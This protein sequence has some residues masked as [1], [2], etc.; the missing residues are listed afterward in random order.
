[1]NNILA[2]SAVV[3]CIC[4]VLSLL[5]ILAVGSEVHDHYTDGKYWHHFNRKA[6]EDNQRNLEEQK[7]A[8]S[9]SPVRIKILSKKSHINIKSK[10][11]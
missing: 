3:S 4:S 5:V 9:A 7:T 2:L 10:K 11:K 8:K 6:I 1:M